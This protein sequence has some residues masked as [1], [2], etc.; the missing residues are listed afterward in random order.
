MYE[1]STQLVHGG[2]TNTYLHI[3][4]MDQQQSELVTATAWH[5]PTPPTGQKQV[6]TNEQVP[7]ILILRGLGD[8]IQPGAS[9]SPV[10]CTST[11]EYAVRIQKLAGQVSHLC[12]QRFVQ[13][14]S[15]ADSVHSSCRSGL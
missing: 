11:G 12:R 7:M 14:W 2:L 9:C 10:A 3:H 8:R 1:V 5:C 15:C 13:S 6:I 4:A